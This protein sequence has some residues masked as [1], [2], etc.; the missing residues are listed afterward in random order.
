MLCMFTSVKHAMDSDVPRSGKD[1]S[2]PGS[3]HHGLASYMVKWEQCAV[4]LWTEKI[5]KAMKCPHKKYDFLQVYGE[6][7]KYELCCFL[8]HVM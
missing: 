1:G 5:H 3:C 8:E 2:S 7:A 6:D 4:L